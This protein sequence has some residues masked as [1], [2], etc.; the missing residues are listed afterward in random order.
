MCG[1]K[2][3][4]TDWTE[5]T[6]I[7]MGGNHVVAL[8]KDGRVFAR[9]SNGFGQCD[10]SN[11]TG[12]TSVAAGRNHTVGL[13]NNGNVIACGL[14]QNQQCQVRAWR[15][16]I[17]IAAGEDFTAG[18][19]QEGTIVSTKHLKATM[20]NIGF[21][22]AGKELVCLNLDGETVFPRGVF[23]GETGLLMV[24]AG[25]EH[26]VALRADGS[27]IATGCNT[28]GQCNVSQWRNIVAVAVSDTTTIGLRK[29][30]T[31]IATGDNDYGQCRVNG[32]HLFPEIGARD[33]SSG[34]LD[35]TEKMRHRALRLNSLNTEKAA[36]EKEL[37][38][39]GLFSA[40][41]RKEIEAR[42]T[43]IEGELKT[44]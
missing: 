3:E 30:G 39:L 24:A 43:A 8:R 44:L 13:Q 9:G 31:V 33:G 20:Q 42:L 10:V 7:A 21:I 23:Q 38:N 19:T 26:M 32:W 16:I 14:D 6:A 11:W 1:A 12:I 29:D 35:P 15:N 28:K 5:I 18:L 36:L 25:E 27:V 34:V 4:V 41:R 40:K 22:A 17:A 37:S 2:F